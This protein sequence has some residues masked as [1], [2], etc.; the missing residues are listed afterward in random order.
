MLL[1][2]LSTHFHGPHRNMWRAVL[3]MQMLRC[4]KSVDVWSTP[5][6]PR[7]RKS[8]HAGS[9]EKWASTP[10]LQKERRERGQRQGWK[11]AGGQ[12]SQEKCKYYYIILNTHTHTCFQNIVSSVSRVFIHTSHTH[13]HTHTF[14][15][16]VSLWFVYV[17]DRERVGLSSFSQCVWVRAVLE[18]IL[19]LLAW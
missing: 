19:E 14:S 5:R 13:T 7:R 8:S 1:V 18:C 9:E 6:S 3:W 12:S 4:L 11:E 15:V 10:S 16:Y 2:C 17:C